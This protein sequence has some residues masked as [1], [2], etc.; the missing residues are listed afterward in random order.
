MNRNHS[1]KV[2]RCLSRAI[3]CFAGD[4]R[5]EKY[6]KEAVDELQRGL[7]KVDGGAND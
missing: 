1:N 2:K 3:Y 7:W 5:E 4:W 6:Q